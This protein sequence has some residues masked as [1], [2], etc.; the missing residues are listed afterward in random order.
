MRNAPL[1]T[2]PP[3]IRRDILAILT[4]DRLNCLV[5]ASPVFHQQYLASRKYVL[6]SC[7]SNTLGSVLVDALLVCRTGST[8]FAGTRGDERVSR[9]LDDYQNLRLKRNQTLVEELSE[10]DAV[11][12][13]NFHS[14]V[15]LPI[16]SRYINWAAH[17]PGNELDIPAF[18]QPLSLSPVEETRFLRSLY[19]FQLCCQLFSSGPYPNLVPESRHN[20]VDILT[21]FFFL[22]EPWEVEETRCVGVFAEETYERFSK[23]LVRGIN[24]GSV[25]FN[26]ELRP[27]NSNL[28]FPLKQISEY[29]FVCCVFSQYRRTHSL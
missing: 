7:L 9:V 25:V 15:I 16:A 1:E 23:V 21:R 13:A 27:P 10:V 19:R 24:S 17:Y 28:P 14:T 5:R 22:H 26:G 8:M 6:V 20:P 4:L 3:E 18:Q 2:L 12:M 11:K 29:H